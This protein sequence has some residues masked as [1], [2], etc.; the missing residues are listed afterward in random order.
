MARKG[1]DSVELI[2]EYLKRMLSFG[3]ETIAVAEDEAE[4]IVQRLVEKGQVTEEEGR[5]IF[6][7]FIGK[8]QDTGRDLQSVID[9]RVKATL[10]MINVPSKAEIKELETR[11]ET[12]GAR[13]D[14]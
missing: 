8:L 7:D 13:L 10:K 14:A 3:R 2:G 12:L 4:K 1:M 5:R 6:N 11:L 9:D